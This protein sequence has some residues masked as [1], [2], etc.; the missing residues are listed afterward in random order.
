M[1]KPKSPQTQLRALITAL[2]NRRSWNKPQVSK[3]MKAAYLLGD[4]TGATR[5]R[6]R[7]LEIIRQCEAVAISSFERHNLKVLMDSI[8]S[9]AI[10]E[11]R[12]ER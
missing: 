7:C 9:K 6:Q 5:E 1:P 11:V 8:H 3:A 4:N 10:D 2:W 12:E